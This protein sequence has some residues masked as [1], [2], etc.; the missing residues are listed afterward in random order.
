MNYKIIGH[1]I[2]KSFKETLKSTLWKWLFGSFPALIAVLLAGKTFLNV[3][4]ENSIKIA[5]IVIGVLIL[6][7]FIARIIINSFKYLHT[8]FKESVYGDAIIELKDSFSKV[9]YYRKTPGYQ[10]EEFMD[11]MIGFCNSLKTIFD[12]ITKS[13]CS[14][15]I[16]VPTQDIVDEKTVLINLCRDSN[17]YDSRNTQKYNQT[18][19]TIIGNTCF[20]KTLNSVL[21]GSEKRYYLN[22]NIHSSRDYDNTSKGCFES[23]ESLPYKSEFV[24][25]IVPMLNEDDKNLPC[26][27]F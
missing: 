13:N 4:I 2:I 5:L 7:R 8:K 14:I 22:N 16:K 12:R 15:S 17:N 1:I 24:H 19:H 9:H 26:H 20:T 10:D 11:A 25:A 3:T 18:N 23:A 21:L 27:G 6:I